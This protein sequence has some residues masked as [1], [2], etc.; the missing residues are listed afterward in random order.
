MEINY[1]DIVH[2]THDMRGVV[3]GFEDNKV[4]VRFD[5]GSRG[6]IHRNHIASVVNVSL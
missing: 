6:Y 2:T 3:V 1:G 4:I 5:D